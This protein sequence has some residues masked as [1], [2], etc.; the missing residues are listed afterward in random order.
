MFLLKLLFNNKK[1]TYNDDCIN[2]NKEY[3]SCKQCDIVSHCIKF[4]PK[5]C[6]RYFNKMK[7]KL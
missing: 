4:C 7:I 3:N 1:K 5:D 2:F 6:N